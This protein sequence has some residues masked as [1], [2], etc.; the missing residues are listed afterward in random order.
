[1]RQNPYERSN[2]EDMKIY[3]RGKGILH[4]ERDTWA[5]YSITDNVKSSL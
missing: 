3:L 1:M 5:K 4:W 2:K